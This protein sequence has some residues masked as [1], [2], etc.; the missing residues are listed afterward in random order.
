MHPP[1]PDILL[2]EEDEEP[3]EPGKFDR[4]FVTLV[5]HSEGN[6]DVIFTSGVTRDFTMMKSA[7]LSARKR[8]KTF[9]VWTAGNGR[10]RMPV[11]FARDGVAYWPKK[12]RMCNGGGCGTCGYYGKVPDT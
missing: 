12:C 7:E 3:Y 4:F 8:G 9:L 5:F 11:A 6:V 1:I 10:T 2:P